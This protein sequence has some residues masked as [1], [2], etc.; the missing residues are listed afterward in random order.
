MPGQCQIS[1]LLGQDNSVAWGQHCRLQIE[2]LVFWH[3][4]H[5]GA[6]LHSN[7]H[8][9]S[10]CYRRSRM[11]WMTQLPIQDALLNCCA[12]EIQ[13]YC[14]ENKLPSDFCSLLII[15]QGI[16]LLFGDLNLNIKVVFLPLNATFLIQPMHH[17]YSSS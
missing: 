9:L 16:F 2:T 15:L 6:F 8:I 14:L 12:G 5:R 13:K 7:K 4:G 11:S 1:R 3:S 10:M 17:C